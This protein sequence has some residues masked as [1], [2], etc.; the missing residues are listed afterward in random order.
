[1]VTR[2]VRDP[3]VNL[4]RNDLKRE[5]ARLLCALWDSETVAV[6][7]ASLT[8]SILNAESFAERHSDE[9]AYADACRLREVLRFLMRVDGERGVLL[10]ER[11]NLKD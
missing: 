4:D 11:A 5:A 9:E 3:R 8:T 6:V 1:M 7:G 2:P 10:T